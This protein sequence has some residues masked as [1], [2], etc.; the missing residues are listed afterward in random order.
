MKRL[1]LI[2]SHAVIHRAFHALPPLTS[3]GGKPVNAVYGF[4]SILLKMLKELKPD[5]AAAAFDHK[6][7]TFRHL[8]FERYKAERAKTPETLSEQIPVV[9]ELVR[10]FGIPLFEQQ[11]YEADDII[12][13]IARLVR[14]KHPDIEVVIV[15]GDL[16]TLQLVDDRTSVFTMRKGVS[17]TV[18]YDASAVRERYGL[19]PSQL[20]DFKGLRGDPSDN[21]PGVKG[22]G[23][24]TA[25]E[26]LGRYGSIEE[27]YR[28]LKKNQLVAKPAVVAALKAHEADALFS[29]TLATIDQNMPITFVLGSSRLRKAAV[30]DQV[31]A[32]FD[33]LGFESLLRRLGGS[34]GAAIPLASEPPSSVLP[35]V[36]VL[37]RERAAEWPRRGSWAL[38]IDSEGKSLGLALNPVEAIELPASAPAE[39]P[40]EFRLSSKYPLYAFNLKGL[41]ARGFPES[42]LGNVRDFMLMWWLLEPGRKTYEPEA[43]LRKELR[44]EAASIGELAARLLAAA[45]ALEER[46]RQEELEEVYRTLEAPLVPILRRMEETGVGFDPKPLRRISAELAVELGTLEARI[47]EAAGKPFNINSPRQLA[48]VLFTKL[49]LAPKGI[50]KTEKS[51]ALSTRESELAKLHDRHP[52]ISSILRYR[53]L[54][55]LKSTYADTLPALVGRDGRIHTTWNQTGTATGRLSSQNPNLQNIPIR[56]EHGRAIRKAF[57]AAKGF[58]LVAFDYSQLELRIAADL[59]RDGKMIEAFRQGQDIHRLTAAEV[60]NIPL[61]KVTPELRAAAKTLNFGVLYG[62]GARAFAETAGVTRDEAEFF[63]EEYF[64]DFQGIARFIE[65]TKELARAKGFTKTAFGRKRFFPDI[66]ASNFR[67]QREAERQAVNH[68]IQGTEADIMKRAMIK[69]DRWIASGGLRDDVRMLLQVHDE[70]IFEVR[71]RR[72]KEAVPEIKRLMEGAWRGAVEMVVGVKRGASWGTLE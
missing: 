68:P 55:K 2:D 10:S 19:S 7:P 15:T 22:I 27:I 30:Q 49:G 21:I 25:S 67:I 1:V 42:A 40:A 59:A 24:K 60:N 70:L 20:V 37:R 34:G 48:E 35:P 11:G 8:A 62:M 45:P 58:E 29:K 33:E 66:A 41:L 9:K 43:L 26:L 5:Y 61:A 72:V 51:G 39:H 64:R 13:T 12:G 63:I 36:K 4:A 52:V 44:A 14:A 65:E 16:D 17:D 56:S 71:K 53:E 46:L 57:V 28:A 18:L 54:A 3:P 38:L 6:G 47:H 69:V 31:R 50:R 32:K 23:E